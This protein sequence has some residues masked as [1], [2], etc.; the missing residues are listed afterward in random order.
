MSKEINIEEILIEI[1]NDIEARNLKDDIIDFE[2]IR[3]EDLFSMERLNHELG[4]LHVNWYVPV[5]CQQY[6][7]NKLVNFMKKIIWRLTRFMIAPIVLWQNDLNATMTRAIAELKNDIEDKNKKI[8]EL[9]R[10]IEKL[11]ESNK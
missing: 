8:A 9:E 7:N 11:R 1:R 4:Y 6:S 10:K 5:D 3:I 2:D